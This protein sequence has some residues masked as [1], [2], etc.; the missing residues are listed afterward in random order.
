MKKA[1]MAAAAEQL[2]AATGWL[3]PLLR[4]A[5]KEG[6]SDVSEAMQGHEFCSQAAE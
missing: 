6:E 2:L 4:T 3:P 5:E 1:K